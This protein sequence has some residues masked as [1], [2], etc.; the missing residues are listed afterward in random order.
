MLDQRSRARSNAEKHQRYRTAMTPRYLSI[1][2]AMGAII[3]A[4]MR[5]PGPIGRREQVHR[6]IGGERLAR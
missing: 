5:S 1:G 3:E 4:A 6:R 2:D